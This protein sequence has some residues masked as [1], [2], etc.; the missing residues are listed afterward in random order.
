[1]SLIIIGWSSPQQQKNRKTTNVKIFGSRTI[2]P[3]DNYPPQ[4]FTNCVHGRVHVTCVVKT[5]H[6]ACKQ[7]TLEVHENSCTVLTENTIEN[8][9][10]PVHTD[11]YALRK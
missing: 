3:L 6:V 2:T 9:L 10:S 11:H 7:T 4:A 5:V 1:M 8:Y